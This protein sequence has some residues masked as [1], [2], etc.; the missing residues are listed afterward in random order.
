MISNFDNDGASNQSNGQ[1]AS[2]E[3]GFAALDNLKRDRFE[4]LSAYMDGEVT[5]FEKRQ[6]EQWLVNDQDFRCLY[7]RLCKLR[8]GLKTMPVPASSQGSVDETIAAVSK[9]VDRRPKV[10]LALVGT[11]ITV[12]AASLVPPVRVQFANFWKEIPQE[13]EESLKINLNTPYT[14]LLAPP[15]I[16]DRPDTDVPHRPMDLGEHQ[17]VVWLDAP[18]V[19]IPDSGQ[20]WDDSSSSDSFSTAE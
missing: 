8:R 18:M 6:V 19:A 13:P 2:G 15:G 5:A 12:L 16:G 1:P 14:P 11:A 4:L 17:L 9:K 3:H 20:S 10:V 7:S